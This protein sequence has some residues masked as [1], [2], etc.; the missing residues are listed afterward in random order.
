[1]KFWRGRAGCRGRKYRTRAPARLDSAS[2]ARSR[3]GSSPTLT[4]VKKLMLKFVQQRC[5]VWGTNLNKLFVADKK[6]PD[7]HGTFQSKLRL[8]IHY[9]CNVHDFVGQHLAH[10]FLPMLPLV[11]VGKVDQVRSNGPHLPRDVFRRERPPA[12]LLVELQRNLSGPQASVTA[13]ACPSRGRP[14]RANPSEIIGQGSNFL[15]QGCVQRRRLCPNIRVV[16]VLR[17]IGE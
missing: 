11:F 12:F 15:S 2:W 5:Q 3:G 9:L 10:F 16:D 8:E 6:W 1:M 14:C 4:E 7:E 17:E 13:D